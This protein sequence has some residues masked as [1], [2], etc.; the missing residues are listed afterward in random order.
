MSEE[1]ERWSVK[2]GW[3]KRERKGVMN[4]MKERG[5]KEEER[6]GK[7]RMDYQRDGKRG[8]KHWRKRTDDSGME[9][10]EGFREG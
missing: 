5:G 4:R 3:V 2:E 6:E 10:K 9:R 8:R 1:K 7:K